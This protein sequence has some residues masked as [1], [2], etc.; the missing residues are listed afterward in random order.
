MTYAVEEEEKIPIDSVTNFDA[1]VQDIKSKLQHLKDNPLRNEKP[2]IYH[3]DVGM[4]KFSATF[5]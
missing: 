1:V 3:L 2:I 4:C 5:L